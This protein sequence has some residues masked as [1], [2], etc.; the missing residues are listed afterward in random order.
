MGTFLS[1]L[2]GITHTKRLRVLG[3]SLPASNAQSTRKVV[4]WGDA[5]GTRA[6]Y[7]SNSVVQRGGG[8]DESRSFTEG[9]E[10]MNTQSIIGIVVV[11]VIVIVVLAL[12][13]VV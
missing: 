8:T 13:G 2:L 9:V 3:S 5:P 11:V 1:N 4:H 12:L 10:Q 6:C 7:R